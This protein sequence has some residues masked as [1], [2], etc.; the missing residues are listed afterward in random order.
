MKYF[1]QWFLDSLIVIKIQILI[2]I[3]FTLF[4]F[5]SSLSQEE[6]SFT[7]TA[8][9]SGSCFLA[10]DLRQSI[11]ETISIPSEDPFLCFWVRWPQD[12]NMICRGLQQNC[13]LVI[14]INVSGRT[15]SHSFHFIY[16]LYNILTPAHPYSY[17]CLDY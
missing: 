4:S 6:S 5:F 2:F 15:L 7:T 16:F 13:Y 10:P 8:L 11:S 1:V 9:S 3:Y 17:S 12:V 14:L